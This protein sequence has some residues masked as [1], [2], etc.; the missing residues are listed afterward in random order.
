[1][2]NNNDFI[3]K[4]PFFITLT[5]KKNTPGTWNSTIVDIYNQNKKHLGNFTR[6]YPSYGDT[7]FYPFK[8][9]DKWYALYSDDYQK[10]KVMELPDCT[11][12]CEPDNDTFCPVEH[13]VP[14]FRILK[15]TLDNNKHFSLMYEWDNAKEKMEIEGSPNWSV[16]Q[17]WTYADFGF[18]SGCHWGDD[19]SWK[20]W[21]LDL[22]GIK[23]GEGIKKYAKFGFPELARGR[24]LPSSLIFDEYIG[25]KQPDLRPEGVKIIQEIYYSF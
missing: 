7:T 2:N 4:G 11:F 13:Y 18:V 21:F 12:L 20:V 3:A 14:Q 17:D 8:Q 23:N 1:M 15:L 6:H 24:D 19:S 5:E 16:Y 25:E 10:T 9:G 22:A